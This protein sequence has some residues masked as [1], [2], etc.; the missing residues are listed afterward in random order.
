MGSEGP[1]RGVSR[2]EGPEQV[3]RSRAEAGLEAGEEHSGKWREAD[4]CCGPHRNDFD[5]GL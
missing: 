1:R 3:G 5:F 4:R 2:W